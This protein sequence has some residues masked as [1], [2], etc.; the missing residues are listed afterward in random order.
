M[1]IVSSK[2][3]A[4]HLFNNGHFS[5][6]Y[7]GI[8]R[9]VKDVVQNRERMTLSDDDFI[10]LDWSYS[11]TKTNKLVILFHGLEG[12]SERPYMQASAKIF[13]V[14]NY[15]AVC[16]NFRGCSGEPNLKYRSYHSGCSND[17][18]EIIQFILETKNYDQI[19][20]K[21]FSLG[22]NVTLKYLGEGRSIPREIKSAMAVS[23]PCFLA[24]SARELH[25]F[26]NILYAKRFLR[27]LNDRLKI[28]QGQYPNKVSEL[29]IR[30]IKT[31]KDFD[32]VYTSKAHG[33]KDALDYYDRCSS[34][35]FLK[36]ITIPT[37]ILNAK[38]DSFLSPECFPVEDAQTNKNLFLEMPKN[39]GHVGFY[40]KGNV[41]YNELRALEFMESY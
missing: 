4:P 31:L 28:K 14:N 3:R 12:N 30:S 27:H 23:V 15:D 41:Y 35:Q 33:F 22:G 40:S 38:N 25:K 11:E 7:S 21:G 13:N 19:H 2:Y 32:D 10:H 17:V 34:L 37:L 1:P 9:T 29:E 18:E 26:N 6:V 16:V 39:G 5:T 20:L 24:G 8:F 36:N